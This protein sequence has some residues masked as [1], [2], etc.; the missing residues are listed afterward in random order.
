MIEQVL[1][2]GSETRTPI[3]GLFSTGTDSAGTPLGQ[4]EPDGHYT[5]V[6]PSPVTG[7]PLAATSAGGYPIPP[8]MAD[9]TASTWITPVAGTVCAPGDYFYRTTFDLTGRNLASASITGEWATDDTGVDIL[10]NGVSTGVSSSSGFSSWASFQ[11]TN[12]FVSGLNT[13]T[14]RVNNAGLSPNPSGFR[15]EVTGVATAG[16]QMHDIHLA[17]GNVSLTWISQP[18]VTYRVQWKASL[19]DPAWTDVS[20][21]V[22]ATGAVSSTT[23]SAGNAAHLF[24]RVA[25]LP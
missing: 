22:V 8:W 14:F 4:N 3:P 9:N 5:L 17:S 20:G 23:F 11:L 2:F 10:L 6:A 19:S 1:R 21:D 16:L 12:G 24:L 15:A 7:T 18:N 13:L 25:A